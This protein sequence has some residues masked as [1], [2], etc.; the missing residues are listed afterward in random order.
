MTKEIQKSETVILGCNQILRNAQKYDT[1]MNITKSSLDSH[2]AKLTQRQ[3]PA[4]V[5]LYSSTFDPFIESIP[6]DRDGDMSGIECLS[7]LRELTDM[8]VTL[9]PVVVNLQVKTVEAGDDLRKSI[10]E[11]KAANLVLPPELAE[12]ALDRDIGCAFRNNCFQNVRKM[13]QK[14][15]LPGLPVQS[16]SWACGAWTTRP[17]NMISWRGHFCR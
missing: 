5:E 12:V 7:T 17:G 10:N 16:S 4:L 9:R 8:L 3:T 1:L 13:L 11:A 6:K 2:I 15:S 14:K